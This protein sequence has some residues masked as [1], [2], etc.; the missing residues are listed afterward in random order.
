[1]GTT[2]DG[3]IH[4]QQIDV[5][6]PADDVGRLYIGFVNLYFVGA[7][8]TP[9]VLVDTGLP[10]TSGLIRQRAAQRYGADS[11][12]HAI[13][14]THGH[15]DHAGNAR[16]LAEEW[17]VPVYAHPL[18]LPYLTGR[19]DYPPQDPTVGGALGFMSRAFPRGG[20]D[21]GGY[22]R[23]LPEDGSVPGAP[24]WRW[25]FT[26]GHTAGH[27]S[28][29][30]DRDRCLIAGDAFATVNQD[31]ALSMLNLRDEF[32]VPPA[33][34]TTDWGAARASVERLADLRPY[35]VGAGHGRPVYG[36]EIAND[37][38]RFADGFTPPASGRYHAHPAITDAVHG[39]V[40]VPP[41]VPDPLPRNLL[42][43]GLLAGGAYLALRHHR[44]RRDVLRRA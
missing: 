13:I 23:P 2:V 12:P 38:Q 21:L 15:F 22:V 17:N 43:A 31:S 34:L 7:R 30:R 20:V 32:S 9:W 44:D 29:F 24:D 33:P 6:E 5:R 11:V 4:S 8:G 35:A 28:L 14:L 40:S 36:H 1:M 37:L 26:P 25:V 3:P 39:V 19:S 16:A 27:I 18:E 10:H 42:L 41:P